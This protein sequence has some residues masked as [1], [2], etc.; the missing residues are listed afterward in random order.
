MFSSTPI[1]W[2]ILSG[3]NRDSVLEDKGSNISILQ[4]DK[5]TVCGGRKVFTQLIPPPGKCLFIK[6]LVSKVTNVLG[7]WFPFSNSS[8]FF[9]LPS[10]VCPANAFKAYSKPSMTLHPWVPILFFPLE[11]QIRRES[12]P[13]GH[14]P[15][16]I[17]HPLLHMRFLWA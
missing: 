13:F 1:L 14:F 7:V 9:L 15:V 8:V 17:L 16:R 5:N 2:V 4:L 10:A 12:F 11:S 3:Q 6:W